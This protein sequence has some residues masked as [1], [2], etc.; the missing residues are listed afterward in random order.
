MTLFLNLEL[1]RG[2]SLTCACVGLN[3]C[4]PKL[5][6]KIALRNLWGGSDIQNQKAATCA[7][8]QGLEK[9]CHSPTPTHRGINKLLFHLSLRSWPVPESYIG[10]RNVSDRDMGYE[11]WSV[12]SGA[13]LTRAQGWE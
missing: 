8:H 4:A 12:T 5:Y 1:L 7:T 11:G 9:W 6:T 2:V 3:M 10:G 13:S